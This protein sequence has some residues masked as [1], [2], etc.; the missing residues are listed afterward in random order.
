M[1]KSQEIS[2]GTAS[3]T[4]GDFELKKLPAGQYEI[5]ISFIG[6][7]T[8]TIKDFAIEQDEI[9]TLNIELK[10]TGVLFSPVSISASRRPEKTLE[11]PAATGERLFCEDSATHFPE[12][13]IF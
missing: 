10:Q 1:V 8:E 9:R 13:L 6:Y 4:N 11:A 2:T 5:I 12:Q 7:A 3:L